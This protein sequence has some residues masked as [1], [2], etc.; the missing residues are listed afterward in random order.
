MKKKKKQKIKETVEDEQGVRNNNQVIPKARI[1]IY[2]PPRSH[3]PPSPDRWSSF[4]NSMR[5]AL[6]PS[7]GSES[8]GSSPWNLNSSKQ[9]K[10]KRLGESEKGTIT[11][12]IIKKTPPWT[13]NHK[14][15]DSTRLLL[16][17]RME[18]L[19]FSF[20]AFLSSLLLLFFFAEETEILCIFCCQVSSPTSFLTAL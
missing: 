15:F 8:L 6:R 14:L 17:R 11:S 7:A 5:S 3:A 9:E 12:G 19:G 1:Y 2:W 16:A 13:S 10:N 18:F 20:F 4:S